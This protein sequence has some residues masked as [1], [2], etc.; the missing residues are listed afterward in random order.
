[1]NLEEVTYEY[2]PYFSLAETKAKRVLCP[3]WEKNQ[4]D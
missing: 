4:I 2:L 1:M 3:R